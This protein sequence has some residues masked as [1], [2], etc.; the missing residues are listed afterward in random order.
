VQLVAEK[1]PSGEWGDRFLTNIC[2]KSLAQFD[3][4]LQQDHIFTCKLV[5]WQ[6]VAANLR[7]IA[8]FW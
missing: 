5:L 2:G 8:N 7:R 1:I 6:T 4:N 3:A